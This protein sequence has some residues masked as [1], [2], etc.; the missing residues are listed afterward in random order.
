MSISP[1]FGGAEHYHV[2]HPLFPKRYE[3]Q[4]IVFFILM[5]AGKD[6]SENTFILSS[7]EN[8]R[9]FFPKS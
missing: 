8:F 7:V 6:N 1:L 3:Q 5:S 9:F 4:D 2:N